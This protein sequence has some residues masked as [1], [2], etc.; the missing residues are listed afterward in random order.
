MARD[1]AKEMSRDSEDKSSIREIRKLASER[2][3]SL[4]R[5]KTKEDNAK[6][7]TQ[8]LNKYSLTVA[9][10][11]NKSLDDNFKSMDLMLNYDPEVA[12]VKALLKEVKGAQARA[13]RFAKSLNEWISANPVRSP[14]I[15]KITG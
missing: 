14:D 7:A 1:A 3:E 10:I 8:H 15:L 13:E 9:K 4:A 6:D 11:F 5:E 2:A 12:T